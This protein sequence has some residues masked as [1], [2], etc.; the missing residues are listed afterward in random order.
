MGYAASKLFGV[1]VSPG[2]F[3]LLMGVFG[4]LFQV[5]RRTRTLGRVLGASAILCFLAIAAL[6]VGPWL[7][8]P[9]EDRFP[10]PALPDRIDGIVV[11]GGTIV[12]RVAQATGVPELNDAGDRIVM[13]AI[14]AIRHP[15]ARI[16]FSGGSAHVLETLDA[17]A[18]HAVTLLVSLGV[19]RH[20]IEIEP[21]S[22]NTWE[23]AVETHRLMTPRAGEAWLLV[24][25]AWHMPRAVG[26]FRAAGWSMIPYPVDYRGPARTSRLIT[27][28]LDENLQI[29]EKA[30]KEWVGLA[31]Y[32][33]LG[34]TPT[35][36]PGP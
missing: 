29:V 17:E 28:D 32:R 14:L 33:L 9:L 12:S 34:R 7:I 30:A 4:L 24:T 36:F 35:L 26:A 6:P 23:N 25:S 5:S 21:E 27:F 19:P 2:N 11:L 31:A 10:R 20:R 22:R 1:L 15:N 18:H 13:A 8:R 16:V 3:L